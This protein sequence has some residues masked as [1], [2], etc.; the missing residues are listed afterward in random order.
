MISSIRMHPLPRRAFTLIEI[1]VVIAIIAIP[2]A[3]VVVGTGHLRRSGKVAKTGAVLGIM[4][5]AIERARSESAIW[6]PS[7]SAVLGNLITPDSAYWSNGDPL[8][9]DYGLR[10]L[11]VDPAD[12]W[13]KAYRAFWASTPI[14]PLHRLSRSHATL[15]AVQ[16]TWD[17]RTTTEAYGDAAVQAEKMGC[18]GRSFWNIHTWKNGYDMRWMTWTFLDAW[19]ND[20]LAI[21]QGDQIVL[22]SGGPNRIY[23]DGPREAAEIGADPP[24][25]PDLLSGTSTVSGKEYRSDNVADGVIVPP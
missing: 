16:G 7:A 2:T 5:S 9:P 24:G 6:Q 17:H 23:D 10:N 21:V 8:D 13:Q 15:M 11:T 12:P 25:F 1:L 3:L 22:V 14:H 20:I 19:A 18:F 4:R